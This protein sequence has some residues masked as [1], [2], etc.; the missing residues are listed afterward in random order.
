MVR[1]QEGVLLNYLNFEWS[2]FSLLIGHKG[3]R[4]H[5]DPH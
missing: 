4:A 2:L 3:R 1:I 5:P